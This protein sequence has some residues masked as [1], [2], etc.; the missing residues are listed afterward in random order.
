MGVWSRGYIPAGTRFGPLAGQVF[1]PDEVP[2]AANRKY[3]WRVSAFD[4]IT[5]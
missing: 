2:P 3:F 1:T 4:L 5:D